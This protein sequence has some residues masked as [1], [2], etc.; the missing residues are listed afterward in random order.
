[1]GTCAQSDPIVH[2][3]DGTCAQSDPIVH[4][5]KA[6]THAVRTWPSHAIW[7]KWLW[8]H[9]G[10]GGGEHRE[11]CGSGRCGAHSREQLEAS[12]ES[13]PPSRSL[14][15]SPSKGLHASSSAH[16]AL[17][18]WKYCTGDPASGKKMVGVLST[19]APNIHANFLR[20]LVKP[21]LFPSPVHL[22][23]KQGVV[24]ARDTSKTDAMLVAVLLTM[25]PSLAYV[26]PSSGSGF[27]RGLRPASP[28]CCADPPLP[29]ITQMR[30]KALKGELDERGVSWRGTCFERAE[31][32]AALSR[33]RDLPS[34]PPPPPPRPAPPPAASPAPQADDAPAPTTTRAAASSADGKGESGSSTGEDAAAAYTTAYELALADANKLRVSELRAALAERQLNWAGI[35]E[36]SE[37]AEKLAAAQARSAL[38]SRSGGLEPGK[39]RVLSG[40]QL[41]LEIED[42]RTP[43]LL[44]V[45]ATWCGPC[46]MIAPQLEEIA[47]SLG[48]RARVAKLDSDLESE[49]STTLRVQGLPTLIFYRGG[50]E[51]KRVEG[52]PGG[53]DALEALVSEHLGVE[54]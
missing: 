9:R 48:S 46:K 21:G 6:R 18:F 45:Y 49:M 2:G 33:A 54:V 38:F 4:T 28:R 19:A 36:K 24:L 31:L 11:R 17:P 26:V 5:H 37:L 44:D 43:M 15:C 35:L 47:A 20:T 22:Y 7:G 30:M 41:A 53:K 23:I 12:E 16:L 40:A 29:A 42:D 14:T 3:V 13:N 50:K 25:S 34:P 10:G 1:M 8:Q 51:V 32:E 52:V 27:S 39:A